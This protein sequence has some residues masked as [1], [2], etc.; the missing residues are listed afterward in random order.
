MAKMTVGRSSPGPK[1]PNSGHIFYG[2]LL[3]TIGAGVGQVLLAG[4][5]VHPTSV[6]LS[7]IESLG[8]AWKAGIGAIFGLLGGEFTRAS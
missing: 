7:V 1:L 8:F 4:L 3:I 2:V 5:W 6:Q